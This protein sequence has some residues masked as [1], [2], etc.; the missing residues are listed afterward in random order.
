MERV[1]REMER[2]QKKMEAMCRERKV[3]LLEKH[4]Q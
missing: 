2:V 4:P 3:G 1:Q